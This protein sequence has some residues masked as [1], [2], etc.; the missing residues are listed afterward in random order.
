MA[1]L[2]NRNIKKYIRFLNK[3]LPVK[4]TAVQSL[5]VLPE[6][7]DQAFNGSTK[8]KES[9]LQ[10]IADHM[11]NYLGLLT[12]VKIHFT[13]KQKGGTNSETIFYGDNEGQVSK[14]TTSK[15]IEEIK[16]AGLYKVLGPGHKEIIIVN[17]TSFYLVH[18]LSVLAHEVTHNY[19][20]HHKINPP[21]NL[22]DEILTDLAAVYLGFGPT[23]IRGYTPSE[24]ITCL[25]GVH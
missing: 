25:L 7:L 12:P 13:E 5:Y 11:G 21:E 16:Y 3:S 8:Q 10:K 22:D 19:L 20:Y 23:L 14:E 15:Y 18:F 6:M 24:A 17:D 4:P 2:T 1:D 9:A